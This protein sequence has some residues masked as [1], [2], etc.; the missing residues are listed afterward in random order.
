MV[1][2]TTVIG[3]SASKFFGLLSGPALVCTYLLYFI[4][5]IFNLSFTVL[6]NKHCDVAVYIPLQLSSQL[7]VNMFTGFFVWEDARYLGSPIAYLLVYAISILAVYML[8]PDFDIVLQLLHHNTIRSS[9][10][11]SGQTRTRFSKATL[12]LMSSWHRAGGSRRIEDPILRE[13]CQHALC[14]LLHSGIESGVLREVELQKLNVRLL[15]ELGP[16]PS[17][18]VV[19]WIEEDVGYTREYLKHDPNFGIQL[20]NTLSSDDHSGLPAPAFLPAG[21]TTT[22]SGSGLQGQLGDSRT[23]NQSLL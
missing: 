17:A 19:Q 3:S 18:V 15:D 16:G 8:S 20:R 11:S 6:A 7:V 5:G 1:T 12:N 4:D 2:L 22:S 13:S 10:L 9:Q 14:D 21:S 23:A